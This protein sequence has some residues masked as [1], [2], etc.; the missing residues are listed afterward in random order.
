M[1][2][3]TVYCSGSCSCSPSEIDAH[4]HPSP[5]T[6]R[7]S[8]TAVRRVALSLLVAVAGAVNHSTPAGSRPCCRVTLRIEPGSSSGEHKFKLVALLLAELAQGTS[9]GW[10][11][12]GTRVAAGST[13]DMMAHGTEESGVGGSDARRR[14]RGGG[15]SG[16]GVAKRARRR[17]DQ[18]RP[19][20]A[21]LQGG[22]SRGMALR[23]SQIRS[24]NS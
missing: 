23:R 4:A 12:P 5:N 2:R 15:P 16:L 13:L 9:E 17:D 7:V 8:V 11:P 14:G 18:R 3:A 21:W 6:P 1:G 19:A 10:G 24:A 20:T 22:H